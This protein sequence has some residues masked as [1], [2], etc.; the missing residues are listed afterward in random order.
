MGIGVHLIDLL[1]VVLLKQKFKLQCLVGVNAYYDIP[2][3]MS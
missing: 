2:F 3:F 1:L